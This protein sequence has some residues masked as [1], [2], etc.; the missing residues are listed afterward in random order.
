[1]RLIGR[2][3]SARTSDLFLIERLTRENWDGDGG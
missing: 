1:M 2:G 3:W